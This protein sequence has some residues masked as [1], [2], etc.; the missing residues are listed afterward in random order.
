LQRRHGIERAQVF[1]SVKTYSDIF[2][3][4]EVHRLSGG[5]PSCMI[6]LKTNPPPGW[7]KR[8]RR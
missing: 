2:G 7:N 1:K 8:D 3:A 5:P 6:F 4:T